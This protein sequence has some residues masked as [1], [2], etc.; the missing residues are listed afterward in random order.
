[1]VGTD[2]HHWEEAAMLERG[3]IVVAVLAA[4]LSTIVA[5][6]AFDET[7]Y[8]D[9]KGLWRRGPNA[10]TVGVGQGRGNVFDPAKAW[11]P[12]QQAPLT[13][14]YQARFE[15]NLADQAAGGQGIGETYACV[16]PGMPRVTNGYGQTEFVVT[17]NT[18][19]I[20]VENIRD[21]RR[22]FTDGREWPAQIEPSLLGYSI[23]RWIDTDGDGKYDVLEVE[24]R[25]FTG[26]RAY[27][28]SGIPLHD[29]NQ[30]IVRERLHLD[31]NDRNLL[32]DEVT[33]IDHALTRPWSV[34]KSYRRQPDPQPMWIE[35]V[36][37]EGNNHVQIGNE[38]Y[39]LSGDGYLM[40][41]KKGQQPPDL[42]YFRR[43]SR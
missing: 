40:P 23:G 3:S 15:A 22:I 8:P 26:P 13:P 25:G 21:S 43:S 6:S 5:A 36:C 7:K 18:T 16:S 10:N 42:K 1:V 27:D 38:S 34:L 17:P 30:T 12:A 33:V 32:V 20:L 35:D 41:T 37:G 14:E 11:G 31:K 24:T 19:H 2:G 29:D 4:L 39:M 9:L 28:A